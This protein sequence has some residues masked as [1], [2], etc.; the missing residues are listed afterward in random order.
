MN[1]FF[2][3]ILASL[4]FKRKISAWLETIALA[5]IAIPE[6]AF[7]APIISSIAG[8]FGIAGVTHAVV[9]KAKNKAKKLVSLHTIAA[10]LNAL[11]LVADSFPQLQPFKQLLVALAALIN[12]LAVGAS[13]GKSTPSSSDKN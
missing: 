6:L 2:T 8:Y 11:I 1:K 3:S 5:L 12:P 4:G 7:A 9:G 10:T 13:I